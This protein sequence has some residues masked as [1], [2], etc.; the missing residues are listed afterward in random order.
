V[1]I[2]DNHIQI[3]C[4]L[5]TIKQWKKTTALDVEKIDGEKSADAW[6]KSKDFIIMLAEE[7]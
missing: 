5:K 4:E 1:T 2:T 6:E 3:G 7:R